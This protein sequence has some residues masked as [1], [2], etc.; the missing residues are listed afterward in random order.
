MT[1]GSD[2]IRIQYIRIHPYMRL[3]FWLAHARMHDPAVGIDYRAS[4]LNS[5]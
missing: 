2:F 3:L 1:F 5:R 4:S